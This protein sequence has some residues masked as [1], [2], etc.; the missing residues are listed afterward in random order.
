M[1]ALPA[2]ATRFE[3]ATRRCFL[4]DVAALAVLSNP[5]TAA[6]QFV[7]GFCDDIG[8]GLKDFKTWCYT[9]AGGTRHP[10]YVSHI[11]GPVVM[12][13]HELPGLTPDDI[14]CA[15]SLAEHGKF[16]VVVPLLFGKPGDD[17]FFR[18]L[19]SE[20]GKDRFDCNNGRRTP[21]A[22]EWLRPLAKAVHANWHEGYG[23]G[24]IGMCLTGSLPLALL[25]ESFV[26]APVLCQPTAPFNFFTALGL[27][28][29]KRAFGLDSAD[30]DRVKKERADQP[31]LAF[32]YESDRY[33][34]EQRLDSLG[35][36][37]GERFF[38]FEAAGKGHSVLAKSLCPEAFAEALAFLNKQLRG[39]GNFPLHSKTPGDI[40]AAGGIAKVRVKCTAQAH[41]APHS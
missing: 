11:D 12:L 13:L 18:Y 14:R 5:G 6:D 29:D 15:R 39:T 17:S 40:R 27:F 20:C 23:L 41:S 8:D 3:T 7:E 22:V 10:V 32:R 37:L 1:S 31:V 33:C 34:P 26:K 2:H 16:K 24:V 38:R 30:L 21:R 35:N 9:D 36:E 4:R 19:S 25:S 28:T